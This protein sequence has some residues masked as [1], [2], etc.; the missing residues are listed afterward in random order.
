MSGRKKDAPILD[1]AVV[2]VHVSTNAKRRNLR[3][4]DR[5]V[6]GR[7]R[8]T[9]KDIPADML[10]AAATE[11]F[12]WN[13]PVKMLDDFS[14]KIVGENGKPLRKQRD[15]SFEGFEKIQSDLKYKGAISSEPDRRE[16]ETRKSPS[17]R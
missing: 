3:P 16:P 9:L 12:H 17:P 8:V 6:A 1:D 7:Y 14:I 13:I 10:E 5:D 2:Y 11:I 15:L 4:E